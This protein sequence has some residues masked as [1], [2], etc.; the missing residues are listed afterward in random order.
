[1]H[2]A[3][4]GF[5]SKFPILLQQWLHL[6]YNTLLSRFQVLDY[7]QYYLDLASANTNGEADWQLEY[8]LTYYYGLTEVTSVSLHN[9]ADRFSNSEDSLFAR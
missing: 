1:M 6:L 5:S 3:T 8:N 4:K 2:C 7:S 9:L